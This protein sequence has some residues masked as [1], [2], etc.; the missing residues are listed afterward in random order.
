MAYFQWVK[1]LFSEAGVKNEGAPSFR[2]SLEKLK[3]ELETA[4]ELAVPAILK[5]LETETQKNTGEISYDARCLMNDIIEDVLEKT[6]GRPEMVDQAVKCCTWLTKTGDEKSNNL[7]TALSTL[8]KILKY[9]DDKPR[10]LESFVSL[11]EKYP[12]RDVSYAELLVLSKD[13]CGI[14]KLGELSR[15][16]EGTKLGEGSLSRLSGIVGDKKSGYRQSAMQEIIRT[17]REAR[18]QETRKNA[19]N[20]LFDLL[21][22]DV[23]M[24]SVIQ[25]L[26]GHSL[27]ITDEL[28]SASDAQIIRNTIRLDGWIRNEESRK[29][30]EWKMAHAQVLKALF[31]AAR[32]PLD[33]ILDVESLKAADTAQI[34]DM[35]VV[36][37][38]L[39]NARF[40]KEGEWDLNLKAAFV[41]SVLEAKRP[42]ADR[43]PERTACGDD[44]RRV[45]RW[46][47]D[48]QKTL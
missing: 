42:D 23:E 30:D 24:N 14:H 13:E 41:S 8:G 39:Q 34:N 11:L 4:N 44:I 47:D 16:H 15:R 9:T 7:G 3:T 29:S 17:F 6:S 37:R 2:V 36:L 18:T 48:P 40:W 33:N 43:K 5:K 27:S 22:E 45:A 32:D 28:V 12:E 46:V 26:T 1:R 20:R 21:K 19:E 31:N 25:A 38:E 35:G 10:V